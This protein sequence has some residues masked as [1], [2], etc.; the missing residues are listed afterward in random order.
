[1]QWVLWVGVLVVLA[2]GAMVANGRFGELPRAEH[3]APELDLPKGNLYAADLDGIEFDVVLRGYSPDQ[4]EDLL[5]R[6]RK[7][8][9][10]APPM[11]VPP[12]Y[13]GA[14]SAIMGLEE[15]PGQTREGEPWQQ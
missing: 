2:L 15:S 5:C 3:D 10:S 11:D 1:M 7:Q 13:R 9:A 8:L 6:V 12:G 4:V 14:R